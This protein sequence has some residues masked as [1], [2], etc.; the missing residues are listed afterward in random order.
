MIV[1]SD[2]W[3]NIG[4]GSGSRSQVWEEVKCGNGVEGAS[5][6]LACEPSQETCIFFSFVFIRLKKIL[7][8]KLMWPFYNA[9]WES[10]AYH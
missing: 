9:L 1:L 4:C 5:P 6:L 10:T 2:Q 8:H 7:L 3:D